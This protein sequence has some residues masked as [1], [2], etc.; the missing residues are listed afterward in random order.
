MGEE[1][2][3]LPWLWSTRASVL[4]WGGQGRQRGHHLYPGEG[5]QGGRGPWIQDPGEVWRGGG[6]SMDPGEG[7]GASGTCSV[8]CTWNRKKGPIIAGVCAAVRSRGDPCVAHA[9]T[10]G[11][12][13]KNKNPPS[14]FNWLKYNTKNGRPKKHQTFFGSDNP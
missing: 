7:G 2:Y 3:I 10:F 12:P 9:Y 4:G 11:V 1:R 6:G 8:A 5:G 14:H 13:E